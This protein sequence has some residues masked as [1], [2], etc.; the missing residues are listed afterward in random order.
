[1][2]VHTPGPWPATAKVVRTGNA[3]TFTFESTDGTTLA[4]TKKITIYD[5]YP[6]GEAFFRRFFRPIHQLD[7]K[8]RRNTWEPWRVLAREDPPT[9]SGN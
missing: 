1:M 4:V 5:R 2:M 7:R 9:T 8:M 3:F 6:L